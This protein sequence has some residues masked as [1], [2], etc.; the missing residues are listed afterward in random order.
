MSISEAGV[1]L[2]D[3]GAVTSER[4]DRTD[5]QRSTIHKRS[6]THKKA[7]QERFNI[8]SDEETLGQFPRGGT[9]SSV[10]VLPALWKSFQPPR[11]RSALWQQ[12]KNTAAKMLRGAPPSPLKGTAARRRKRRRGRA[13]SSYGGSLIIWRVFNCLQRSRLLRATYENKSSRESKHLN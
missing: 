12:D 10:R 7:S 11:P 9:V 5:R 1:V 6:Q 3:K 8:R 2:E 13:S 4:E